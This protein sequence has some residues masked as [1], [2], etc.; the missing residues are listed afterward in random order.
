MKK[1]IWA[2]LIATMGYSMLFYKQNAGLNFLIFTILLSLMQV[3]ISPHLI[4]NK[5]WILFATLSLFSGIQI[6]IHS[7]S[8][9]IFANLL[10]LIIQSSVIY[11]KT[12][13][14][15][16]LLNGLYSLGSSVVFI[17]FDTKAF[18]LNNNKQN[19]KNQGRKLIIYVLTVFLILIFLMIYKNI[20]PLFEKYTRYITFEFISFQWII[21]TFSGFLLAYGFIKQVRIPHLDAWDLD[22]KELLKPEEPLTENK[23]EKTALLLLFGALNLMLLAIN[24][25]DI[26]YLYLGAGLPEG[27]THKQFVHHGVGML[28]LSILL[29]ITIILYS[30]RGN[31]NF[32]K[33]NKILKLLVYLWLAQNLMMVVS[34]GFRNHMYIHEAL[35]TYKR[36]GVYYWLILAA[37]GLFSTALKIEFKQRAWYLLRTNSLVACLILTLSTSVDWDKWISDFNFSHIRYI[38]SL[39]KKY[40]L[41]LSETNLKQL[42][43][44]KNQP[45]FEIDS[46]YHYN[47]R[48]RYS[49]RSALDAKLYHFLLKNYLTDW[50]SFNLRT[51]RILNEIGNLNNSNALDTFDLSETYVS[52]IKPILTLT[53]IRE[54]R[55][56]HS[57]VKSKTNLNDLRRLPS[58]VSLRLHINAIADT[59]YLR[60]LPPLET[61]YLENYLTK[62]DSAIL[63]SKKLPFKLIVL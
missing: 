43:T 19:A 18:F 15:V 24:L 63:S 41:D 54:M 33:Q 38:A 8:L 9:A 6:L 20:N 39:D 56:S 42:Y 30:F 52:T 25:L 55:L 26:N 2:I 28:I 4:K 32:D 44:I 58:L 12:S 10:T 1:N 7:S 53:G 61:L 37:T 13:L 3:W 47:Y 59:N 17:L 45:E 62:G 51:E 5:L 27:I 57:F 50:R 36:I 35:L 23:N 21:F 49:N 34:T 16:A 29:G 11:S 31:L 46:V 48:E 22:Q 14:P 40:L 60:A